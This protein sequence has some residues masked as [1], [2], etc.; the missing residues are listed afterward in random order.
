MEFTEAQEKLTTVAKTINEKRPHL[1]CGF[2]P[3]RG[4]E[5]VFVTDMDIADSVAIELKEVSDDCEDLIIFR[6]IAANHRIIEHC[7]DTNQKLEELQ[8]E[9]KHG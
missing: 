7:N 2:F 8:Q 6:I 5:T 4:Q 3:R 9:L 1:L